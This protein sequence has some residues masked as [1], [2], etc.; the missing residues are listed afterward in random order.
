MFLLENWIEIGDAAAMFATL[1]TQWSF[2]R[3]SEENCGAFPETFPF[4]MAVD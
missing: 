3:E 4:P 1:A 2:G